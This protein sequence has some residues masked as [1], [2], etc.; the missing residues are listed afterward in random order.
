MSKEGVFL[1]KKSILELI[2]ERVVVLDGAMGSQLIDAGLKAGIPSENWNVTNPEKVQA[3]QKGYFD[4]GSDAV[5]T[6]TF[7]GTRIKLEKLKH[8]D[9]VQEYNAKAVEIARAV[10]P[11]DC[12]VAGDIGPTGGFLAPVGKTTIDDFSKNFFEQAKILAENKVDFFFVETMMDIKEAEAAVLAVKKIS[13]LPIFASIT[14]KRT[15][16][17]FF[18][19][20]GNP[21]EQCVEIL[22]EAGADVIGANCTIGSDDMIDLIKQMRTLTKLPISAKPNAGIPELK[23]GKT[24][25]PTSS[26]DFANDITK[27]IAAGVNVVGGCCGTNPIFIREIASSIKE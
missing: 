17:G 10:C 19:E 12:Y 26:K 16:R 3:I 22:E 13:D 18:T 9:F 2:K 15:K 8:G 24:V 23:D 25:Y 21:I 14:Y 7:G 6:N 5:L 11:E 20:M 27:I 4:A 1:P